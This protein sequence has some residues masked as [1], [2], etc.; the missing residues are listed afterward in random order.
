MNFIEQANNYRHKLSQYS[1][2]VLLMIILQGILLFAVAYAISA[3]L[4]H[5]VYAQFMT[6]PETVVWYHAVLLAMTPV[7]A[8]GLALVLF[9]KP[10]HKADP[11]VLVSAVDK[12]RIKRFLP[13]FLVSF[14]ILSIQ[15]AVSLA[16]NSEGARINTLT[17]E[18]LYYFL[19]LLPMVFLQITSEELIFRSYLL[20]AVSA[21]SRKTWL[22]VLVSSLVFGVMHVGDPT[23]AEAIPTFLTLFV[24]G[25]VLSIVTVL[26]NGIEMAVGIHF[27]NN[28]VAMS[29][30]DTFNNPSL[31]DYGQ[32]Q[33]FGFVAAA[34]NV[35][36]VIVV[37]GVLCFICR[38]DCK[39]VFK[40]REKNVI[41][42][43]D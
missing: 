28:L 16:T 12:I 7:I 29:L 2:M 19:L 43:S 1:S 14:L 11:A 5:N 13:G 21:Y 27:A 40:S 3:P 15:T 34:V 4:K 33:E 38:W 25:L 10:I 17:T 8:T 30:S 32:S 36:C 23:S 24:T 39:S 35:L 18:F 26:D 22:P 31:I 20:Q 42:A 37:F 41:K 9:F 6:N